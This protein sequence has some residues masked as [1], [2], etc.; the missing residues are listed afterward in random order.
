M[1]LLTRSDFDG[2]GCAAL[3]KEAG[4]IDDIKFVHPKDMQDGKVDVTENDILANVPYVPDCGMWFDHHS[5]EQ[6]R[7]AH[8]GFKGDCDPTAASAARVIYNYFGGQDKF[9]DEHLRDLVAAALIAIVSHARYDGQG[10]GAA[11]R[12]GQPANDQ[13]WPANDPADRPRRTGP[14]RTSLPSCHR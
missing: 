13:Q 4:I 10:V 5:S 14:P 2:L 9:P 8:C 1:R 12:E 6:E 7:Q 11:D 3:L